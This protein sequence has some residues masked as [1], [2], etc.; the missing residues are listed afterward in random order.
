MRKIGFLVAS[1]LTSF[2]GFSQELVNPNFGLASHPMKIKKISNTVNETIFELAIENQSETG[3][4]C[5][6]RNIFV[7]DVLTGKKYHLNRSE[8]IPV[9][10]S[11]YQFNYVGEVLIFKLYFPKIETTK[12]L[13]LIEDCNQYCFSIKGIIL[14]EEM[15]QSINSGYNYYAKG[16]PNFAL[17]AYKTAINKHPDYPFGLHYL[18]IIQIYA[19]QNDFVSAKKWYNK[20]V[21]SEFQDK[22]ELIERL[23]NQSYYNQLL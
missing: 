9:C 21:N 6:D 3:S 2:S 8:G 23:R 4:F 1:I 10:P 18:N 14:N 17:E 20:I 11:N 22:K 15:N 16:M 12:Y 19:E 5:A 7:Q 13:T